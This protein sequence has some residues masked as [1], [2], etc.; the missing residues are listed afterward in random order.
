M[1][2]PASLNR[3]NFAFRN[4]FRRLVTIRIAQLG[5]E[6]QSSLWDSGFEPPF[7]GVETP[8]YYQAIP[9]GMLLEMKNIYYG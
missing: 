9:D 1:N 4:R 8:G 6:Y 5:Y 7:P 2:T 3:S